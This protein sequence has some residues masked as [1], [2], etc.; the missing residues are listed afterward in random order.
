MRRATDSRLA[1]EEPYLLGTNPEEGRRLETQHRLWAEAARDLWDRAGFRAGMRLLDLGC[2]PGFAALELADRVG[3]GGRAFAVD[4]SEL[5]ITALVREAERL[6]IDQLTARVERV[7]ELRLEPASLDGAFVRWLFCFLPDPAPVINRV[8]LGLRP[9]G[10]LVVWDY[11]NYSATTLQP[12]SP[13]FDRVL[14]AVYESWRRTGGSL[15][16]GGRL[17]GLIAES[18]CRLID[19]VPLMRFV[20]PGTTFWDWPTQFF[21]GYAPRLVEAGLLTEAERSAFESEW[22]DRERAPGAFLS[23]PP[24]IGIIAEK[25]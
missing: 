5:F 18:G 21:F 12:R 9:G 16:V 3:A 11:L 14:A 10:R 8:V 20:R 17:P 22:R 23:T 6:G 24:M 15:N 1:S 19:L 25:E 7:E 4:E 2:G 13:A